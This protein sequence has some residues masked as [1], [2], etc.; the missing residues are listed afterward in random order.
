MGLSF[1]HISSE[2]QALLNQWL[3]K[4]NEAPGKDEGGRPHSG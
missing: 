3:L 4:A 1:K 2:N